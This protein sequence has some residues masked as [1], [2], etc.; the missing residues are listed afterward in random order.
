[1]PIPVLKSWPALFLVVAFACL[2][3]G[4]QDDWAK[5][6]SIPEDAFEAG[7]LLE[8]PEEFLPEAPPEEGPNP[9]MKRNLSRALSGPVKGKLKKLNQ[10][11]DKAQAATKFTR[12]SDIFKESK[13]PSP[14]LF[15]T[16]SVALGKCISRFEPEVFRYSAVNIYV[17]LD[18]LLGKQVYFVP[19][20]EEDRRDLSS[21]Q[22]MTREAHL[23]QH[24]QRKKVKTQFTALQTSY[25][26]NIPLFELVKKNL[27]EAFFFAY[28][29]P[30]KPGQQKGGGVYFRLRGGSNNGKN[31]LILQRLCPYYPGC[32]DKGGTVVDYMNYVDATAYCYY[33]KTI[34]FGR[35]VNLHR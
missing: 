19:M 33:S 17:D 12:L 21:L 18:T 31:F 29:P 9:S 25:P 14:L 15:K 23:T 26:K 20:V 8:V 34:S 3:Q 2:A 6:L 11:F 1:M 4:D 28:N 13:M 22:D 35:D 24:R 32:Q 16:D 5:G 10:T 30:P 27:D 7:E